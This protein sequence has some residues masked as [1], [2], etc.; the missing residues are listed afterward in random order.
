MML[1]DALSACGHTIDGSHS[2]LSDAMLAA[3]SNNLGAGIL[4]VNLGGEKVYAVADILISRNIPFIFVT[5]YS[6][7]SIDSRF[8]HVPVLQ[9][10]IEPQK[11]RAGLADAPHNWRQHSIR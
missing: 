5:G 8:N 11:L 10:P 2:R 9:K 7:D 4:D 6:A 1:A 3:T